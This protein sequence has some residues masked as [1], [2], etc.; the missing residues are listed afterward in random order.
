MTDGHREV[1]E[2]IVPLDD[3]KP[4]SLDEGDDAGSGTTLTGKTSTVDEVGFDGPD[5]HSK[6]ARKHIWTAGVEKAQGPGERQH[7][8]SRWCRRN[9][10]IDEVGGGFDHPPGAAGGA[11]T[12]TLT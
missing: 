9:D 8:L 10:V 11:E 2:L 6:S 3:G 12:P 4:K 1:L 7:P 5:N